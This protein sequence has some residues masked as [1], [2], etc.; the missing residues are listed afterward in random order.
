MIV[1]LLTVLFLGGGSFLLE[2]IDVYQER[3]EEIITEQERL[4]PIEEIFDR[5]AE[6]SKQRDED[7]QQVTEQVAD[8]LD[9]RGSVEQLDAV[10]EQHWQYMD[11]FYNGAADQL[12][13]LKAHLT[14]EEWERI[15]RV[16]A[17]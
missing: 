14:E 7:A 16:K 4:A 17:N 2:S 6:S 10:W 8:I 3:S 1:A 5:M 12:T 11:S 13:D 15:F 9:E